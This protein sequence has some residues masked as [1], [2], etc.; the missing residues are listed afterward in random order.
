MKYRLINLDQNGVFSLGAL[1]PTLMEAL[2]AAY[3]IAEYVPYD[4]NSEHG[5]KVKIA[6][7]RLSDEEIVWVEPYEG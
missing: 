2:K 7:L 5:C 6:I 4:P 3:Q 1:F